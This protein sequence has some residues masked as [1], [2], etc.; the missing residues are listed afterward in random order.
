MFVVFLL[1]HLVDG[2]A[3]GRTWKPK[4]ASSRL[5]AAEAAAGKVEVTAGAAASRLGAAGA[6]AGKVY[7]AAGAAAGRLLEP[8][9]RRLEK[10]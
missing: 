5:G 4:S 3:P 7:V 6:A 1:R 10:R 2:W 8:R 9:G